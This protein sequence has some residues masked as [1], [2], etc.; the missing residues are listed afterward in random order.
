[1]VPTAIA[2][3]YSL[4]PLQRQED[5]R[6]IVAAPEIID[7]S[8]RVKIEQELGYCLDLRLALVSEIEEALAACY[9]EEEDSFFDKSALHYDDVDVDDLLDEIAEDSEPSE[10][11][12]DLE[13]MEREMNEMGAAPIVRLVN[14]V[15]VD[16]IRRGA[17]EIHVEPYEKEFRIRLRVDGVLHEVMKPPL[18]L[19][20]AM[21]SRIKM[22][23]DLDIV[24]RRLPQTGK[25]T[26]VLGRNKEVQFKVSTMPVAFGE[27][28]VLKIVDDF[29]RVPDLDELGLSL[30]QKEELAR[31]MKRKGLILL[32]GPGASGKTTLAKSLL[33]GVDRV[34]QNVCAI[35]CHAEALG[36]AGLNEVIL[37]EK[38]GLVFYQALAGIMEGQSAD[39]IFVGDLPDTETVQQAVRAALS[40]RLVIAEMKADSAK[41]ALEFIEKAVGPAMAGRALSAVIDCR[42]VRR[43]CATCRIPD[44]AEAKDL[45]ALGV[46][47]DDMDKFSCFQGEGC[48]PC[49][50]SGYKGR[51]G[52]YEISDL[53]GV[54]EETLIEAARNKVFHGVTSVTEVFRQLF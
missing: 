42:L 11:E 48:K 46:N 37:H 15:L 28:A 27:K 4:V 7:A 35:V 17:S 8:T 20:N 32:C 47:A 52:L 21:I 24:Q 33:C 2:R 51:L 39:L 3:K 43:V 34:T 9:G 41:T 45:A 6:L 49:G 31:V 18:R 5:T 40:G 53:S 10:E 29:R 1:M 25:I 44:P 38:L 26:L 36:I 54:C 22:M 12:I 19:K 50:H 30:G 13:Q 23:A 16:S 14:L